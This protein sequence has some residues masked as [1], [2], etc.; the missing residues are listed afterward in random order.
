MKRCVIFLTFALLPVA[1]PGTAHATGYY[2]P[3]SYLDRGGENVVASPEFYWDLEVKRIARDFRAPEKLQPAP[4][5]IDDETNGREARKAATAKADVA[6]FAVALR[7]GRLKPS[8]AAR[9]TAQHEAARALIAA[10]DPESTTLLPEEFESEFADYHRGA[11]AWRRGPEHWEEARAAWTKLLARPAEERRYRTVWATFMLGKLAL[12][13]LDPEA[14]AIFQRTRVLARE[15]FVDSL[16][17]AAESYGWEARSEWKQGHPE[18]AAPLF[19]TQLALGDEGAVV[20]LKALV[21]DRAPIGGMLNY[22][23][24]QEERSA[25]TEEQKRAQAEKERAA[26]QVAARDP[27]LRRLVTAH[28]LATSTAQTYWGDDSGTSAARSK[29]WLA[30]IRDAKLGKIADAEYLGW[31]AYKAGEYQEAERWLGLADAPSAAAH[32]LRAKLQRRAGKIAEAAQSMAA[33]WEVIRDPATYTGWKAAALEDA[34]EDDRWVHDGPQWTF[35]EA[36]GG[37][38][39]ALRLVRADFVQAFD[40]FLRAGLNH[41]AAF[42]A[43]RVLTLDELKRYVEA[44]PLDLQAGSWEPKQLREHWHYLLGRR[45]VREDQYEEAAKYLPAPFDKIVGIYAQALHDGADAKL[46]KEERAMG[47]F[48]AAWLARYD[49]MELMGTEV[50]PDAFTTDGSFPINDVAE[51][52]L[53]GK[54]KQV[55]WDGDAE[56]VTWT[57]IPLRPSPEEVRRLKANKIAP[58]VRFHYRVIA[59]ALAAKAADLLPDQSDALADVLNAAGNWVKDRDEKIAGRYLNTLERRAAQTAIGRAVSQRHWFVDERGPWSAREQA[60]YDTLHP[61]TE[62]ANSD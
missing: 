1:R 25:W 47:W 39:A 17:L 38:L 56:K 55:R 19:L 40:T 45:L 34:S 44:M 4:R 28:L 2:G 51:E 26:L 33:A 31:A 46:P 16:G 49:G 37:D 11:F 61:V 13:K 18:K 60:A 43:E 7:E 12:K 24:E 58:D 9:A 35:P 22:G 14:S 8:D 6:D 32:W 48:R 52:R 27:L 53:A 50:A 21:P 23:P 10:T 29:H 41:D 30:E 15:G 36:A 62:P 20:S 42:M 59:G 54:Y 5:V 57:P 3:D